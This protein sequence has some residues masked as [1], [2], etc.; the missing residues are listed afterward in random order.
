MTE[1][2][3]HVSCEAV[4]RGPRSGMLD[5]LGSDLRRS[6]RSLVKAPGFAG[7]ALM[8]LAIGIG[9]N[10]ALFGVVYG[11]LIRPLPFPEPGRLVMLWTEIAAEGVSEAG[12]AQANVRDWE[13]ENRVLEELA[14]FDPTTLTLTGGGWAEQ[15]SGARVSSSF[16]PTL[17]VA[18]AF[19][20]AVSA[21]DER[22]RAAVAVL[23]HGF[24]TR[25][26]GGSRD[27]VGRM[28]ELSDT[29]LEVV[30]VMPAHFGIPGETTDLWFP[31]TLAPEWD[32]A[33][34]RRGTD[35]WRV[36]GR[37]RPGVTLGHARQE[38]RE[39]ASRLERAYPAENAGLGVNVVS[40]YDQ[41]TGSSLRLALWTL[42]GAAGLVFLIACSNVAHLV[43]ARGMAR[44]SEVELRAALGATTPRLVRESLA[45][46]LVISVGGGV[47]GLGL[48][49]AGLRGIAA[50]VPSG[51]PR[52]GEVAA[53]G[54]VLAFVVTA[55]LAAS[56]LVSAAPALSLLRSPAYGTLR[57]G[58]SRA[59]RTGHLHLR[60]A[61]IVL[62]F[63]LAIVLVF[64][65]SLLVR[66]F[67]EAR[68]VDPGF[69]PGGVFMANLSVESDSS[70]IPVYGRVAE[71]LRALP[72][73]GSVALVEDQFISGAPNLL[74]SVERAAGVSGLPVLGQIRI[75]AIL[76]DYLRTV[77]APLR[78]GRAF[79][80]A[81]DANAAPVALVN[82]TMAGRFWPGESPVGRRFRMGDAGADNAW[83][84]VVG[85]V[86]DMR[87]RGLE[88]A[89]IPQVF[90]PYSQSPS[91]NMN[92]LVRTDAPVP[93]IADAVRA[94]IAEIDRTVP[95]YGVTTLAQALDRYLV[96]RRFESLVLGLF[97]VIA[98]V[99]AAVGIYG[100]MQFTVSERT[101]EIGL[102][103]AL[104]A[105]PRAP[106]AMILG[107]ALKLALPGVAAGSA[108]A[109]WLGDVLASLLYNVPVRDLG[110]I[111]I[112]SGAVLLTTVLA[113]YV[114]AAR[115][116]RVDPATTLRHE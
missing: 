62:Q 60:R 105:P 77:R 21:E 22:E 23:S 15:I 45:E 41:V 26:F 1:S 43:L 3:G 49:V 9:V 90:R 54:P 91:R 86:G 109:L 65:A 34:E 93:G 95:L 19:G 11:V 16:F 4:R 57:E 7:A 73:V 75:D 36:V 94:R 67:T 80:G 113:S 47:V 38:F 78:A 101:Q 51:V 50:F 88:N 74:I 66:S 97:S 37:L 6:V 35:T 58:R 92:L 111:A 68:R 110:S 12:S 70:R 64:G 48:A 59:R 82:E 32:E 102:R 2:R 55:S 13:A 116:A 87:R 17:G 115:A 106:A 99:L 71:E 72:G 84:E 33:A 28:L 14:T 85:V 40:L 104:G 100:L 20:R 44:A 52:M 81:D 39:I 27:V 112:T 30:G 98:L 31:Q 96:E 114:P 46:N 103:L 42:F 10:A 83:I 79:T 53:I 8:T 76:G 56:L 63:A 5:G 108:C 61:L 25:R 29:T 18:P 69:E 89:P 107:Q 24:W